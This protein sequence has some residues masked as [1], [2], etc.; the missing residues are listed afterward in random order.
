MQGFVVLYRRQAASAVL[1]ATLALALGACGPAQQDDPRTEIPLVRAA[2][3]QNP[4]QAERRF[5]GIVVA[6]VQSDLGFR[7]SG[8]VV[9]R[10][11]DAGQ[12]VKRGQPLMR[13]DPT[14][15]T[16]ATRA[17]EQAV[18]AAQARTLQ[19]AADEKRYR[20]LVSAGAVSASA[21]DR[22]K[23][24]ADTAKADLS[25]AQ[26]QANVARNE[27]GYAALLSDADGVV[28]ETLAEPG[29]VVNAGQTVVRV[30]RAGPREAVI[31]LPE[32]IRPALGSTGQAV[33]YGSTA[34]ALQ[35]RLRQLSDFANPLTRTFEARYVLEK[36]G[37]DVPLGSTVTVSIAQAHDEPSMEIPLAA[38][39]DQGKG[40]GVWLLQGEQPK[41]TWRPVHVAEVGDEAVRVTGGLNAG[42]RFVAL[43]AHL[44]HEGQSV[45]IE[46]GP[47]LART[48]APK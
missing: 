48:E 3:A 35:V 8:K 36:N 24:A 10:L 27:A 45:R 22:I 19:T 31:E 41:V 11:V 29:Q 26:A 13:I 25:A 44:L 28:M 1:A 40:P 33:L 18:S 4:G 23:A 9:E 21:Y 5:T 34:P 12:A 20:E 42:D 39:Y 6:R 14:D 43:G 47:R 2:T 30:A 38:I 17:R 15:F 7:V 16:L 32:T 37:A 46:G